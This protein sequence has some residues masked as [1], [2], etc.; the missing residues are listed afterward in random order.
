MRPGG[1]PHV[2]VLFVERNV[3]DVD[4]AGAA[5]DLMRDVAYVAVRFDDQKVVADVAGRNSAANILSMATGQSHGVRLVKN[6]LN[7][8][9]S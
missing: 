3:T 8:S 1:E 7:Y 6:S 2:A 9:E 4:E 5:E